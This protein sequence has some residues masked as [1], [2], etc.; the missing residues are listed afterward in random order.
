MARGVASVTLPITNLEIAVPLSAMNWFRLVH[1]W[2]RIN[3]ASFRVLSFFLFIIPSYFSF[4]FLSFFSYPFSFL[5]LL[6]G[7]ISLL[8]YQ[9]YKPRPA[10]YLIFNTVFLKIIRRIIYILLLTSTKWMLLRGSLRNNKGK[11]WRSLRPP[12]RRIK[13][14]MWYS[15]GSFWKERKG[16]HGH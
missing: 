8:V 12:I 15:F 7:M 2:P 16:W 6:D 14:E 13:R 10:I 5:S 9:F 3:F 4:F 11:A 1:A